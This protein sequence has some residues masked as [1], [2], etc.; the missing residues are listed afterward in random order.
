MADT[1]VCNRYPPPAPAL[2]PIDSPDPGNP[3]SR[4]RTRQILH[5]LFI[6][7]W[8][9]VSWVDTSLWAGRT[10]IKLN[11]PCEKAPSARNFPYPR[12]VSA[13]V[14]S[15][16]SPVLS[17]FSQNRSTG[18]RYA[19]ISRLSSTWGLH[20]GCRPHEQ[21]RADRRAARAESRGPSGCGQPL[22]SCRPGPR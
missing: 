17:T 19:G 13:A 14:H 1:V 18:S 22:R 11:I 8:S 21:T 20:A 12:G 7:Y 10:M 6:G 3:I 15:Q 16:Q 4:V 9:Q 5:V 2:I